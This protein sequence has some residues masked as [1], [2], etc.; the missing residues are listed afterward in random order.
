MDWTVW[1]TADTTG[2]LGSEVGS[3]LGDVQNYLLK[4]QTSKCSTSQFFADQGY[5]VR[6]ITLADDSPVHTSH[7]ILPQQ[8]NTLPILEKTLR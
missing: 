2:V 5:E 4:T 7:Q 8:R 3:M 1:W 6:D